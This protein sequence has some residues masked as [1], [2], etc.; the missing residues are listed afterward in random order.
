VGV[1]YKDVAHPLKGGKLYLKIDDL[2]KIVKLAHSNK[3]ELD[4][5]FDGGAAVGDGLF[6]M[7]MHYSMVHSDGEGEEKG[8]LMVERKHTGDLW[9]TTLK[10]TTSAF[11]AQPIIPAAISNMEVKVH[12]DRKTKFNVIYVN[13]AK[14]RDLHIHVFRV[15][16][17]SAKVEIINGARMHDFTFMVGDL[18]FKNMDGV[19][20]I[21]IDGTSLGEPVKGKISGSKNGDVNVLQ[22]ELEK[23]KQKVYSN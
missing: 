14:N 18:N 2:K 12:S 22:M 13:P 3:V 23:G 15:P 21:E 5:D 19:F 10:T 11:S 7:V 6:K 4:I 17:K 16:G 20:S 9:T 1:K 8:E